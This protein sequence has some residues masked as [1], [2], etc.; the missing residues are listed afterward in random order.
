MKKVFALFL[1]LITLAP[2]AFACGLAEDTEDPLGSKS[3][4]KAKASPEI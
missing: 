2:A 1:F 4:S 3:S